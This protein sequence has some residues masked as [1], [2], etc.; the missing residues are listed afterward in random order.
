M[1]KGKMLT[2]Y[3]QTTLAIDVDRVCGYDDGAGEQ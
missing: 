2:L 1:L 3:P